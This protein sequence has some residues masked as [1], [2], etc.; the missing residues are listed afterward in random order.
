MPSSTSSS[1]ARAWLATGL[2]VLVA[3]AAVLGAVEWHWRARGYVPTVLDST[4][5]WARQRQRVDMTTPRALVLLGASRTEYGLDLPTLRA[6]LPGYEPVMLAVNGLYPL[7]VLR[8][9]AKDEDFRGVVLCD[10]ESHGLLREYV[11]LQQPWVD[12]YHQRWTPS[13]RLHRA[14]LTRWQQLAVIANPDFGAL[15][16]LRRAFLGG[17]PFRNYVDYHADRSGDIDYRKTDPEATKR[18]FA[19]TVEG[20]IA[21]MPRRDPEEWLRD[22]APV[23][24]WVRAIQARGG[25]V[26][27]YESPTSGLTRQIN[28][29]LFP[30]AQYWDRFAAASP[31]P[32]LSANAIPAL[33]A[34]P[35]PDDSHID[36]RDKAAY[37]N[38]LVDALESRKLLP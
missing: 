26:I 1:E 38:R 30:P 19:E 28:E 23:F 36:Y 25:Q 4:Q 17:E 9:L 6:R 2:A 16:S 7:A 3:A 20:N 10:I 22:L 8:D 37:T 27:F 12:Y 29:R 24:G 18:H 11:D 32:A 35:L 33:A 31:A 34:T 13:W 15:A 5:L 21:R 14:V